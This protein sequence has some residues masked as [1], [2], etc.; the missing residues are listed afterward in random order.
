MS[1]RRAHIAAAV[2]LALAAAATSWPAAAQS[3]RHP[4]PPIDVEAEAE[5]KSE[6]WEEVVRPGARRYEH[7]VTAATDILRMRNPGDANIK[8]AREMLIEATALRGDLVEGWGYLGVTIEKQNAAVGQKSKATD[9]KPCADAY[10]KAYAIDPAW[11]PKRL[12]SKSDPST[13][14]KIAGNRPLEL[15]WA[16]CLARAGEIERAT[17]PLEALVARGEATQESWMRLGEVYMAAGRLHEAITA[18]EQARNDRLGNRREKW[19]LAMAYDRAR[20]PGEADAIAA[21]AGD[22]ISVT[23]ESAALFV[24]AS[25]SWYLQAFGWR[26]RPGRSLALFRMYLAKTEPES[27]WRARAQEHIEALVDVDFATHIDLQGTGDR[28]AIEK[29]VRTAMPA[30]RRCVASVPE[31]YIELRITQVG[32][33]KALP[34]P[35][36]VAKPKPKLPYRGH[37]RPPGPVMIAPRTTTLQHPGVFAEPQV[38]EPGVNDTAR[39]QALECLEKLGMSLSL[40]RPPAN[41]YS[42]VRIPVVAAE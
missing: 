18:L 36:S 24:P 21:D 29:V 38:F 22:I 13:A 28:A 26:H 35:K 1:A 39:N 11:R 6:F 32:P 4:K 8:R 41:T 42:T 17:E 10:G 2:A 16:T 9:W 34:P 27:P 23:S 19:L 14:T 12:L 5:A 7:L 40:P 25:D 3:T 31:V 37:Y 30:I 15:A 33:V 20:R